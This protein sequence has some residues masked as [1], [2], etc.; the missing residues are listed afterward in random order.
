MS[1]HV[2][3]HSLCRY[4]LCGSPFMSP[5]AAPVGVPSLPLAESQRVL[6]SFWM[7]VPSF[8]LRS[9]LSSDPGGC[10]L[11]SPHT[12]CEYPLGECPLTSPLRQHPGVPSR[13]L[14]MLGHKNSPQSHVILAGPPVLLWDS[15]GTCPIPE[16]CGNRLI[17]KTLGFY[18]LMKLGAKVR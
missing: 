2:P 5:H 3:S 9:C 14:W 13:S 7:C 6:P 4:P 15:E 18:F 8:P 17:G 1:P 10:P 12:L 11:M 16:N